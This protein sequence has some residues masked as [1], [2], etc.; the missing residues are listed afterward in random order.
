MLC[1]L[2]LVENPGKDLPW[3]IVPDVLF[4]SALQ[5]CNPLVLR[6]LSK[7]DDTLLA[8]RPSSFTQLA[9]IREGA[10]CTVTTPTKTS[11]PPTMVDTATVSPRSATA[12]CCFLSSRRQPRATLFPYTT[13]V[14]PGP[15]PLSAHLC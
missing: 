10:V 14:H 13:L 1:P 15:E 2:L 11:R 3:R 4:V 8:H 9:S 12:D 6:V 7:A 5:P